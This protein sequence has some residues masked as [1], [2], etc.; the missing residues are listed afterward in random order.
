MG[1]FPHEY[2]TTVCFVCIA[3][4]ILKV[5][6]CSELVYCQKIF[7]FRGLAF[8]VETTKVK[9][10]NFSVMPPLEPKQ[11]ILKTTNISSCIFVSNNFL[12]VI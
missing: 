12:A 3:T 4:T 7:E 11:P 8:G 9:S 2:D 5:S 10:A 6:S 1:A